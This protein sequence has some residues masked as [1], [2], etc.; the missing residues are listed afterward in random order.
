MFISKK[1]LLARL[2]TYSGKIKDEAFDFNKIEC[3]FLLSDKKEFHQIISDRTF[4]DL[5]MQEMNIWCF[6]M[7]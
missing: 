2:K 3:F 4:Q 6:I 5:D 1:K 7:S